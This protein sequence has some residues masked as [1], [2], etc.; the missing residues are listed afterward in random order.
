MRRAWLGSLCSLFVACQPME[1]L[2]DASVAP[3]AGAGQLVLVFD[4]DFGDVERH[5]TATHFARFLNVGQ[6]PAAI[7]QLSVEGEGFSVGDGA[8]L[9]VPVGGFRDVPIHFTP[10]RNGPY[11]ARVSFQATTLPVLAHFTMEGFGVGALQE[12][13]PA[14]V[15]F[16]RLPL[17][18]G[19][20]TRASQ[21]VHLE[22]VGDRWLQFASN[23]APWF[24]SPVEELCL[25]ALDG[26]GQCVGGV[27]GFDPSMGIAPGRA[28]DLPLHFATTTPGR[29]EWL[30]TLRTA[31]PGQPELTVRARAD[32]VPQPL[33]RFSVPGELDFGSLEALRTRDLPLR[34]T[35]IGDAACV[36][37]GASYEALGVTAFK[38]V[39]APTWPRTVSPGESL[40]LTVRA[41]PE[42]AGPVFLS[43]A[44]KLNVNSPQPPSVALW[45]SVATPCLV[46]QLPGVDFGVQ[47]PSCGANSQLVTVINA[48]P[49]PVTLSSVV[50]TSAAFSVSSELSL[51]RV[52]A[53]GEVVEAVVTRVP[54]AQEGRAISTLRFRV[55]AGTSSQLLVLPVSAETKPG[56]ASRVFAPSSDKADVLLVFDRGPAMAPFLSRA[57]TQLSTLY[58]QLAASGLDFR[59]G[60]VHGNDDG[61]PLLRSGATRWLTPSDGSDSRLLEFLLRPGTTAGSSCLGAV[62]AALSAPFGTD[63]GV[64]G[65][66]LRDGASLTV[67]CV[68][69]LAELAPPGEVEALR[70]LELRLHFIG[71]VEGRADCGTVAGDSPDLLAASS[72]GQVTPVCDADWSAAVQ[73]VVL[74][75]RGLRSHFW[76]Q[77]PAVAQSLAVAV[78]SRTLSLD[79][80][81]FDG[82]FVD[83]AALTRDRVEVSFTPACG[84]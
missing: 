61:G 17:F 73:Q 41:R 10:T 2:P 65:G 14:V 15:D 59:L 27:P 82:T 22:N 9:P 60:V 34:F 77:S 52:V 13:T 80:W 5:S 44:L 11:L 45:V 76:L 84:P 63:T 58:S 47:P 54:D 62:R 46:P 51:P 32:V 21:S 57:R 43:D 56:R 50:V 4:G 23:A 69:G 70:R 55:N 67:L 53:P 24:A 19:V 20:V 66:F 42:V 36:V 71:P 83:L 72:G 25:G 74:D 8:E 40:F 38:L 26:V 6:V 1:A 48:C 7:S 68:S 49:Q 31:S 3:D 37:E 16:G 18:E 81:T 39:D 33:C 28:V 12:L 75:A 64:N 35:N 78:G 79:E 30:I 29:R